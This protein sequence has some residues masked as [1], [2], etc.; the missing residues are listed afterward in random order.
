MITGI[1]HRRPPPPPARH[2]RGELQLTAELHGV[3]S[4]LYRGSLRSSPRDRTATATPVAPV[5]R[6]IPLAA[7]IAIIIVQLSYAKSRRVSRF[8]KE[9]DSKERGSF[10]RDSWLDIA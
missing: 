2:P 8:C 9:E 6:T 1:K 3:I 5:P 4:Q 7:V 10:P